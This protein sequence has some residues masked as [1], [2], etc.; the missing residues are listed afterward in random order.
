[1]S[2]L[3]RIK[4]R[5]IEDA[6]AQAKEVI[7]DANKRADQIKK[8]R[9]DQAAIRA[10]KIGAD[11]EN[12]AIE[13]K[14]QMLSA[15]QMD[16]RKKNL[17]TKQDLIGQAFDYTHNSIMELP[18]ADYE[19]LMTDLVMVAVVTGDEEVILSKQDTERLGEGF[20][21]RINQKLSDQGRLGGLKYFKE[22]GDF[23]GGFIL[24]KGGVEVNCTIGALF[25]QLRERIEPQTAEIL[26]DSKD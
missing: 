10:E 23:N 11:Y 19:Q 16:I 14:R 13:L 4:E 17:S 15:A 24:R 26:F 18:L 7:N 9:S 6:R 22:S 8:D 2:G 5:I 21:K 25:R 1:M 20:V 12:R 3:D